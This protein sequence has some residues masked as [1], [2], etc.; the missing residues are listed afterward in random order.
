MH[1]FWPTETP[2]ARKLFGTMHGGTSL[3]YKK[4]IIKKINI[5]IYIVQQVEETVLRT[6]NEGSSLKIAG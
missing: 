5:Y 6:K 2:L 4:K 3:L 1:Q